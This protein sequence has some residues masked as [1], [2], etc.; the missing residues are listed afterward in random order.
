MA[1]RKYLILG[2]NGFIGSRLTQLL[3]EENV[4]IVG[5]RL[6]APGFKKHSYY[7]VQRHSLDEIAE[8]LQGSTDYLIIDLSYN[9]IS[10]T[11]PVHPGRDFSDNLN[12]VIDNLHFARK[13]NARLYVYISSGGT[14]YGRSEQKIIS[15]SHPTNPVSHY[16]IIKLA[17]EKYVQM[18]GTQTAMPFQIVRPS[19]VYGPGQIPYRGQGII[20]TALA[21]VLQNIP[22]KVFGKGDNIRDFIYVDDFCKWLIALVDSGVNGEIYN[23]GS[24]AGHSILDI[25]NRIGKTA[26]EKGT[27]KYEYFPDRPFDVR[28]N[29]LDNSKIIKNTKVNGSVDLEEGINRTWKWIKD[30][31]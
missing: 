2:G 8:S 27:L 21:S 24:G 1:N 28:A 9:S 15:E 12:L 3:G 20:S 14:V 19:N 11:N 13:L 7:S 17:A 4:I 26:G 25:L 5:R 29:I 18:Y 16:G 30:L 6:P 23:A 10:N 22:V 31:L